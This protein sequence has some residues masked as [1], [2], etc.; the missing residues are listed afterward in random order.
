[1][2]DGIQLVE[3]GMSLYSPEHYRYWSRWG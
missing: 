3:I 2:T 1:M